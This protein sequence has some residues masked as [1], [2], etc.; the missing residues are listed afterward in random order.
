VRKGRTRTRDKIAAIWVFL[1]DV[2]DP[3]VSKEKMR[4]DLNEARVLLGRQPVSGGR[5]RKEQE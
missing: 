2:F 3:H 4:Q 5:H 1:R